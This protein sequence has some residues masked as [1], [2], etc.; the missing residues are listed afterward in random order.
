MLVR[1]LSRERSRARWELLLERGPLRSALKALDLTWSTE[2]APVSFLE[3]LSDEIKTNLALPG[4][5][6]V[7]SGSGAE[8]ELEVYQQGQRLRPWQEVIEGILG[9]PGV[10]G[11][12]QGEVTLVVKQRSDNETLVGGQKGAMSKR[13]DIVGLEN[14]GA[15]N[16]VCLGKRYSWGLCEASDTNGEV[17]TSSSESSRHL[18]MYVHD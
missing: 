18:V 9:R 17:M 5:V 10:R 1:G 8:P 11:L 6:L 13:G 12:F 14:R 3:Q 15:I 7:L 4:C 2:A 16:Q